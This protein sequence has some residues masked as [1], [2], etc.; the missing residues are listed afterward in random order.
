MTLRFLLLQRLYLVKVFTRDTKTYY[1][2]ELFVGFD[3]NS[4]F[5]NAFIIPG[6][7]KAVESVA[8]GADVLTVDSS[9]GFDSSGTIISGNNTIK[10]TSK[11]CK[12]ILWM[13]WYYSINQCN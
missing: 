11:E 1:K 8:I 4:S 6:F 9:I 5:E 7:S 3:D 12:S 13:Q 2:L 10:F